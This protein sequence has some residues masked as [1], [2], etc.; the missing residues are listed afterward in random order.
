VPEAV[1]LGDVKT[2]LIFPNAVATNAGLP[3][4]EREQTIEE[5]LAEA[6]AKARYYQQHPE[7][8]RYF[9]GTPFNT[10]GKTMEDVISWQ[11]SVRAEWGD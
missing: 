4:M 6:D 2:I 7:K 10:F 8:D 3:E 5:C 1:E 11:R 9:D